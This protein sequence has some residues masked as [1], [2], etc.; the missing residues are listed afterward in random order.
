MPILAKSKEKQDEIIKKADQQAR[1]KEVQKVTGATPPPKGSKPESGPPTH[2][3]TTPV[4]PADSSTRARSQQQAGKPPVAAV[5]PPRAP[6]NA[7]QR[8]PPSRV[9]SVATASP[10][11]AAVP[12]PTVPAVQP[13]SRVLS[14][15][16]ASSMRFNAAAMEF[17]PN[18]AASSFNPGAS[19]GEATSS[20]RPSITSPALIPA[21]QVAPAEFFTPES[22]KSKLAEAGL[23]RIQENDLLSVTVLHTRTQ[24]DESKKSQFALTG[25]IPQGYRTAPV[26]DAIDANAEKSYNDFFSN[27]IQPSP[28]PIHALQNG[29]IPHQHQLPLHL[30]NG[31][32]GHQFYRGQTHS[33][34]GHHIEHFGSNPSSVQ[35]S[36]RMAQSP[37]MYNGQ[38]TPQM[39][40]YPFGMPPGGM[41]PA[42]AMRAMPVGGPYMHS[43]VPMG[44]QMMSPQPSSG[45]YAAHLGQQQMQMYSSPVPSH[46]QPHFGGQPGLPGAYG[47]SP[48]GIPMSQQGSQQGTPQP[49]FMGGQM[50]MMP[51]GGPGKLASGSM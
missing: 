37:M 45:P 32:P 51:H 17:K 44:G 3:S 49:M 2:T 26:W 1:E 22:K 38:V 41:S 21:K 36:P 31:G 6:S 11:S 29:I 15:P 28:S 9:P 34:G 47:G 46:V 12:P 19:V 16:S 50:M 10:A 33:M 23:D 20:K 4:N 13:G 43:G 24:A 5:P 7:D 14:P 27:S 40:A 30:Q 39:G 48:R 18:P 42:M 35:P 8:Q 25:G